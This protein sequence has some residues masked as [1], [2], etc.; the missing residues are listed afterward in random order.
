MEP[1]F[2]IWLFK[3]WWYHLTKC[4]EILDVPDRSQ[5]CRENFLS[6][7]ILVISAVAL[8]IV[9]GLAVSPNAPY[10]FRNPKVVLPE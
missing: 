2:P 3:S 10:T 1:S 6:L 4:R 8:Y 9:V 5:W 7:A